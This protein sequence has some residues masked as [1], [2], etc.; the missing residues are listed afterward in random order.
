M[1]LKKI[2]DNL[3]KI[4]NIKKIIFKNILIPFKISEY[5]KKFYLNIEIYHDDSKNNEML[6]YY[7]NIE[8]LVY[9]LKGIED[10][11]FNNLNYLSNLKTKNYKNKYLD[12]LKVQISK[13]KNTILTK[14]NNG[15][16]SIFDLIPQK[17]YNCEIEISILWVNNNNYG[18]LLKLLNINDV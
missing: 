3:F 13:S 10:I 7:K 2:N 5:N 15:N 8:R 12:L 1:E 18:I 4:I 6:D 17:R 11:S 9:N 16:K 14:Y